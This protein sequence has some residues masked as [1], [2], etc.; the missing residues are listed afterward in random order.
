VK[1]TYKALFLATCIAFSAQASAQLFGK[2]EPP[3]PVALEASTNRAEAL[4]KLIDTGNALSHKP[5][6]YSGASKSVAIGGITFEFITDTGASAGRTSTNGAKASVTVNYKLL[7]VSPETMQ[8]IADSF[9]TDLRK[10]ITDQG[11]TVM[12]QDKL[13]AN[14]DFAALVAEASVPQEKTS[15]MDS[16]GGFT[17]F[18]GKDGYVKVVSKGTGD[19][20]GLASGIKYM[21]L[22][23]ALGGI[24]VVT[25]KI[26]LNFAKFE[27]TS[28]IFERLG[29][30]VTTRMQSGVLLTVA[31]S[32]HISIMQETDAGAIS[33]ARSA[34]L[35]S[36]IAAKV[37]DLG[38]SKG[39]VAGAILV[40]LL[41]GGAKST[42]N[43][44]VT[45]VDNY[46][47][48]VSADLKIL[49]E[50]MATGLKKQ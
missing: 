20:S 41:G 25:A 6:F 5:K 35:P 37:V 46:R 8:T 29:D 13:L 14:A 21:S 23:K 27:D 11:Y 36:Q 45:A 17:F 31:P 16:K 9:A 3:K 30:S 43:Y 22:S 4:N 40:G 44:E 32:S 42:S 38:V 15:V 49:A 24:P 26:V 12:E 48:V 34:V 28:S 33:L 39:E 19:I 7:G 2:K 1:A 47:E 50:V 18:G 10:A